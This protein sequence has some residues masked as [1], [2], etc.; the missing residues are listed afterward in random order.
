MSA[1][2]AMSTECRRARC[3]LKAPVEG[4]SIRLRHCGIKTCLAPSVTQQRQGVVRAMILELVEQT[5]SEAL[6]R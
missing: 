5:S 6:R 3:R 2:D 4:Y 1:L